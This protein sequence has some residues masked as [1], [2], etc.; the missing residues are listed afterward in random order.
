M[1]LVLTEKAKKLVRLCE[2]E[3]HK[4]PFDLLRVVAGDSV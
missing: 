1:Q 3:G 4:D 2:L